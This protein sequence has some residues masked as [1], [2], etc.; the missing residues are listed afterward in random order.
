MK[1][2]QRRWSRR[3]VLELGGRLAAGSGMALFGAGLVNCRRQDGG[4]PARSSGGGGPV[5][6]FRSR[7]DLHPPASTV[8][9]GPRGVA[10][11]VILT[12]AHG[13]PGQQGPMVLDGTGQLLWFLP[14]S[15]H[16]TA[17][18]RAFN[19]RVQTY[20]GEPVLCWF[21]GAVVDGH[22]EG[23]YEIYDSSYRK[24][25]EVHAGNGYAGDL[26]EF[27]L[28]DEGTAIFTCYGEA[29]TDLSSLGG[30]AQGSYFYCLVQEVEL[31][32][33]RVV[34]E[35]RSD[36]HVPLTESKVGPSADGSVP[37]DYFHINSISID[38]TDGN[39]VVSG[40]NTWACYKLH[41]QTGSLLW[42]LGG[43]ASDFTVDPAAHFAFQHDVSAHSN[44]TFTIFDNEAG[45][46][47]EA[48][49]SRGLVVGV[50]QT[51]R[52]VT[53]RHAFHHQ[54][55][56]LSYALGSVQNLADGHTFMGWGD[57]AFFTEYD[58]G[59]DVCF[60]GRLAKGTLSYRAFKQPWQGRPTAPPALA[61]ERSGGR[62]NVF[63]SWNGATE[64]AHWRL[65]T[66]P[67]P[68]NLASAGR[69]DRLGF[70]TAITL[71]HVPRYV[72]VE[73]LERSGR[74]LGRS[75]VQET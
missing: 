69:A 20:R 56:V 51:A 1:A 4:L 70:E 61:T 36:D 11:G 43:K 13:G 64:V 27:F 31:A 66:G 44:G 17:A 22:G 75:A 41:R 47:A 46:P 49:A 6:R 25:T 15:G 38:P 23:H 10:P 3:E 62:L 73:G 45:P 54:P 50:D 24:V 67:S 55:S 2:A 71:G 39:L 35:W 53:F 33:G 5:Q 48:R 40:R 68:H 74:V 52:R 37:F 30:A 16:A 7:P 8:D 57:S 60:D 18:L 14:L 29:Q 59:G 32:T 42:R 72:A 21:Q 65:L 63:V 12:D 28:T 34:F 58:A 9:V 19:L 26:H